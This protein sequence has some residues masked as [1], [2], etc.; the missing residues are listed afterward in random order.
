MTTGTVGGRYSGTTETMAAAGGDAA[1]MR[2]DDGRRK[3][4]GREAYMMGRRK[5]DG[6]EQAG[7]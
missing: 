4:G 6:V 1:E 7:E 5:Y 3:D 2:G